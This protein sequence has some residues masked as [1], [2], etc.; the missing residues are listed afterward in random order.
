M[1][2]W[3]NAR[4]TFGEDAADGLTVPAGFSRIEAFRAG[5]AG[6]EPSVVV[7]TDSHRNRI[8]GLSFA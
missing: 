4:A 5:L 2:V 6:V 8:S 3:S 7:D 1:T